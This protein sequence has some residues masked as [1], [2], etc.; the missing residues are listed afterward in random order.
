MKYKLTIKGPGTALL[1]REMELPFPS[2]QTGNKLNGAEVVT[3]EHTLQAN[4]HGVI[5]AIVTTV[6]LQ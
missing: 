5:T 2:F 6:V 4:T 1:T 3:V